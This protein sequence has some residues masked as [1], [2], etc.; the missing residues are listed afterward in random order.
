M[1]EQSDGM[2]LG[3]QGM[4]VTRSSLRHSPFYQG[5]ISRG[6]HN[7]LK[8]RYRDDS[9]NSDDSRGQGPRLSRR[10]QLSPGRSM[11]IDIEGPR[12]GDEPEPA[13]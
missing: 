10:L 5:A 9:V 13:V 4:P 1:Y 12:Q 7:Y 8:K 6:K 3:D 2:M 11:G